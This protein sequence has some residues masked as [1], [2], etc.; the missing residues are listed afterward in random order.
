[1]AEGDSGRVSRPK[2]PAG[3]SAE[4]QS[5]SA[6][7]SCAAAQYPSAA[8]RDHA[9]QCRT[10]A[11]LDPRARSCPA[12]ASPA[13]QP[14]LLAQPDPTGGPQAAPVIRRASV[15]DIAAIQKVA[16]ETW[17]DT[18]ENVIPPD[19][20]ARILS[21]AYS[22][23]S[24][25][26]SICRGQAFLVAEERGEITG[27]VDVDF[28]GTQFNLHRLYVLPTSQRS[29][30][31]RRLLSEA[32]R[33]L[34]PSFI[35]PNERWMTG[36]ESGRGSHGAPDAGCGRVVR[37]VETPAVGPTGTDAAPRIGV[38]ATNPT[39][40]TSS[41]PV[42]AGTYRLVAHV[43]RDNPKARKFYS[44][45]GFSEDKEENVVIGGITLPLICISVEISVPAG[46]EGSAGPMKPAV[47]GGSA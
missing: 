15:E 46:K 24:L 32:V 16:N 19:S 12:Q 10:V 36:T 30:L 21:R 18:Y 6:D 28:D 47:L 29:G 42:S 38:R 3:S 7:Q 35:P 26:A 9:A 11:S 33:A 22:R 41:A 25:T 23:Q 40:P 27:Y 8:L 17:A 31:G 1:M 4:H 5:C 34:A 14:H 45:M 20:Q 13:V 2:T 44:K 37:P 39:F 43:E